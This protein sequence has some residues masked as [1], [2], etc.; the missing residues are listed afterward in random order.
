[1]PLAMK[2][3]VASLTPRHREIARLI[4]LGC[5]IQEMA[6]ILRLSPSTVDNHKTQLMRRLGTDKSVLIT[7][8]AMKHGLSSLNDKLTPPEKRRSGRKRDGWN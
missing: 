3:R 1:M 8:L 4:S 7:R 6:A 2:A 5:T